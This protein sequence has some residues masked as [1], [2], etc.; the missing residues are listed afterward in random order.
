ISSTK[1]MTGHLLGAAGAIEAAFS[2]LSVQN[3]I[4][5]PTI[6]FTEGDEDSEID[7]KLNYTF[8]K[9]QKRTVRAALS[10]TFGFGGHNASIIVK[11]F[12]K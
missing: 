1:S 6:N 12:N 5:P 11:K 4:V 3:D 7:Y 2:V 10:N 8:N 9:A